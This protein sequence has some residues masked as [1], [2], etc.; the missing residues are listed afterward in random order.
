[1]WQ[2]CQNF[3]L[4]LQLF[5]WCSGLRVKCFDV[6]STVTAF[7]V[8]DDIIMKNKLYLGK[9]EQQQQKKPEFFF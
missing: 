1:M 9:Q 7:H 3:F 5:L 8:W 6:I 2:I 4:S